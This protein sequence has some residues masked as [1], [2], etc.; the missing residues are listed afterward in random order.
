M[1]Q[2]ALWE[3]DKLTKCEIVIENGLRTFVDV[4]TALLEIR[5]DKLYRKD[6]D[7]FEDY[8]R[9]RWGMVAR[10]ARQ[11][12]DASEAVRNLE[13]GTIVPILPAN[14]AQARPL[15]S[16]EP[17][18]QREAWQRVI[19][20]A[21]S[22]GITAAIVLEAAKEIQQ[23]RREERRA[24]RIEQL[25]EMNTT[26]LAGPKRYNVIYADPPWR[27]EHSISTSREIENQYP[28]MSLEDICNLPINKI[29]GTDCV[30]FMWATSP[31]LTEAMEVLRAWG[32]E[33]RTNGV[34]VKDKI[35]MGYYFRQQHELL[36]VATRGNIPTPAPEDRVSSVIE[37]PRTDHSKKPEQVYEI[38]ERMYGDLPMIELFCRN[39]RE[40]WEAWGNQV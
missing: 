5:D 1:E 34:W 6:F 16:L 14:E 33:Y 15:V 11:L 17:E 8:C 26:P 37:A 13:M 22:T 30:L 38:I 27:Y 24:E 3:Q 18:Q 19:D 4:G 7:T 39:R 10:R 9:G 21:P 31:K 25:V 35:G 20:K 29:A 23:E 32:F 36:L 2:L 12:I 40:G 28:T